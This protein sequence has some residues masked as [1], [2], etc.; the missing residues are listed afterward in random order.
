M[1]LEILHRPTQSFAR[2]RLL[3]GES[4]VGESGAMVGMSTNVAMAQESGGLIGGL[5]RVFGGETI[6]RNTFSAQGSEGEVIFST[7]LAGDMEI[8]DVGDKQ[9][10]LQNSAYV[11]S[12]T[13]VEVASRSGKLKGFFSG[14]GSFVLGTR[15]SGYVVIGAF[16]AIEAID[17]QGGMV[18][19]TGHV[20]AW[21]ATLAYK[22][23]DNSR[24]IIASWLSGENLVCSFSGTG[25]A[26]VQTRNAADYGATV[27]ALLPPRS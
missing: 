16:G 12:S 2:V 6:F 25:R 11:A 14:A 13:S 20:I 15:G 26:Y 19:D 9:W 17:V 27:G 3:P 10:C 5:K 18:I 23:E 7:P 24:G 1:R 8:L 4:F 21:E 22:V